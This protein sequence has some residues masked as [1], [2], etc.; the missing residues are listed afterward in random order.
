MHMRRL[1]ASTAWRTIQASGTVVASHR[2]GRIEAGELA[3]MV[4]AATAGRTAAG[5]VVLRWLVEPAAAA[6]TDR[7]LW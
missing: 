7:G 1:R 3:S 2:V 4:A 6:T 5:R